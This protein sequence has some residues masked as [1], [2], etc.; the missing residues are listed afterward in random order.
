M[1]LFVSARCG[2]NFENIIFKL[3]MKH[4]S[5]STRWWIVFRQMP[6]NLTIEKSILVQVMAWWIRQQAITLTNY[7]PDVCRHMSSLSNNDLTTYT[8]KIVSKIDLNQKQTMC[9]FMGHTFLLVIMMM[10]SWMFGHHLVF[11]LMTKFKLNWL[12]VS[13]Y[14]NHIREYKLWIKFCSSLSSG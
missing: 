1:D 10:A 14:E 4:S 7:D 11:I 6:Q 13:F 8:Q 12:S 2:S 9:L 5:M 3:I